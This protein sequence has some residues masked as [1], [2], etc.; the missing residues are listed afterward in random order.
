M[1]G[2]YIH[3]RIIFCSPNLFQARISL[4]VISIQLKKKQAE[5]KKKKTKHSD[6][7]A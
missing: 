5:G 4:I 3:P 1:Y 6:A 2:H 7:I